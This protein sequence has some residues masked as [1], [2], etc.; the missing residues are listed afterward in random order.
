MRGTSRPFGRESARPSETVPRPVQLRS[1]AASDID[2][3]I[4]YLSVEA[5]EQ[6]AIRFIEALEAAIHH[7]S[8]TPN[9]G[10]LKFSYDLGI[11]ELRAWRLRKLP[12][13]IFYVP[14]D[15]HIDVWRVLHERRDL[16]A[17]FSPGG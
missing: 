14:F 17:S 5:G 1:L 16:P 4:S 7:V 3:V 15:E 6:A 9:S 10:S 13:V 8:N 12:S 11:P 2:D